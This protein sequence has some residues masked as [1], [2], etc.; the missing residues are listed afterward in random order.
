MEL[1]AEGVI[2]EC[3]SYNI[4][5]LLGESKDENALHLSDWCMDSAGKEPDSFFHQNLMF[6][7]MVLKAS[8]VTPQRRYFVTVL[9]RAMLTFREID[10]TPQSE[11]FCTAAGSWTVVLIYRI[12][13]CS[14]DD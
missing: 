6:G 7:G 3:Y 5:K 1:T 9:T 10:W 13:C 12:E 2:D 11:I 14:M 4:D 8:A